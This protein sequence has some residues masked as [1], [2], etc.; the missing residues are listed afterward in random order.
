[1]KIAIGADHRGVDQKKVIQAQVT[2]ESM[3]LEWTDVGAYSKERTD[4]PLF[5]RAV[6]QLMQAGQ[7]E[8]GILLCAT[9]VGMAIAANR[10]KGIYAA[11][12]WNEE[13]ARLSRES[14]KSNVLVLPSDFISDEQAVRMIQVWLPARFAGGRYQER[15]DQID[16]F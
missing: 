1:M 10:F 13:I 3:I 12:A 14:D 8:R 9:G 11:L 16:S 15:I 5:A 6:C 4:Y 7:V 2:V